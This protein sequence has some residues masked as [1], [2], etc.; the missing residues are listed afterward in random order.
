MAGNINFAECV[1]C[2]Q[3]VMSFDAL[4]KASVCFDEKCQSKKNRIIVAITEKCEDCGVEYV[5]ME[6]ESEHRRCSICR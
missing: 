6:L 1:I 5:D 2:R 4:D 3:G